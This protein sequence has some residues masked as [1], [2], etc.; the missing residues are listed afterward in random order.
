R[1]SVAVPV[2]RTVPSLGAADGAT[3]KTSAPPPAALAIAS[4]CAVTPSGKP[5][6]SMLTA[7]SNPPARVTVTAAVPVLP[8]ATAT[9]RG[10]TAI[11]K[12]DAVASI[13]VAADASPHAA[14]WSAGSDT[15][16]AHPAA[17]EIAANTTTAR[18]RIVRSSHDRIWRIRKP[19]G[20]PVWAPMTY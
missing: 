1:P 8:A 3:E 16:L 10:V 12:G 18:A 17:V 5:V 2:T 19:G 7:S 6:R 11:T 20:G 9:G 4:G 15:R 14:Q 13:V